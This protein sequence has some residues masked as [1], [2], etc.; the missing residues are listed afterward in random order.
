MP[1]NGHH[2]YTSPDFVRAAHVDRVHSTWMGVVFGD[3]QSRDGEITLSG[4]SHRPKVQTMKLVS[5]VI[6]RSEPQ[7]N[8]KEKD[9]EEGWA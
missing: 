1:S 8:S 7:L 3:E 4:L 9:G 6:A 2:T 5:K